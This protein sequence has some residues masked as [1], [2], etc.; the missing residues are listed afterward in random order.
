L[1]GGN[2]NSTVWAYI[3]HS[4]N[5]TDF[6]GN[7]LLFRRRGGNKNNLAKGIDEF[8]NGGVFHR[9]SPLKNGQIPSL[10]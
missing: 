1:I 5:S 4:A 9:A 8:K 2:K 7:G 6:P 10:K 3:K